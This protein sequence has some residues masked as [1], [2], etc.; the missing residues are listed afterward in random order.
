MP[1]IRAL[2]VFCGNLTFFPPSPRKIS[3]V[4]IAVIGLQ[5][6]LLENF[7]EIDGKNTTAVYADII[8]L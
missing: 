5:P 4:N 2:G 6:K 8:G 1:E 7:S 3:A